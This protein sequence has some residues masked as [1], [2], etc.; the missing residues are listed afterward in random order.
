MKKVPKTKAGKKGKVEM[1]MHEFK[2]GA[3]HSGSKKG[4]TVSSRKQAIAIAL[5]QSGQ[6]YKRKT[7][8]KRD[9]AAALAK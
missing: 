2:H 9:A 4:P 1:V 7:K 6:S 5:K 3:L 8:K